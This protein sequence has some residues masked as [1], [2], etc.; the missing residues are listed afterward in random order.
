MVHIVL[1]VLCLLGNSLYE[2]HIDFTFILRLDLTA[3]CTIEPVF[4]DG[5]R[6]ATDVYFSRFAG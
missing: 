2:I 3:V 5:M 1:D 4:Y 6:A